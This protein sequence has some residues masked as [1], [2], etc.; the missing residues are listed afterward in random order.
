MQP[1]PTAERIYLSGGLI[2]AT[3]ASIVPFL[4]VP[5]FQGVFQ[6]LGSDLPL[7][8]LLALR[9]YPAFLALPLLVVG[10]WFFWPRRDKRAWAA[11]GIGVAS[12]MVVPI[13]LVLAM[14]LPILRLGGGS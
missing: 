12:L 13:L 3:G 6:K 10:A 11:F 7:V 4:I 1:S 2:G 14:Y 8:T 5:A 9:L